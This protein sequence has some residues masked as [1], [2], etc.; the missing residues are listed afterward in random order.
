MTTFEKVQALFAEQFECDPATITLDTDMVEDLGADSL[1]VVELT[2]ALEEEFN[3]ELPAD[4]MNEVEVVS[5]VVRIL[6]ELGVED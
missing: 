6:K 4:R 2:M 1:D 5:D 3:V